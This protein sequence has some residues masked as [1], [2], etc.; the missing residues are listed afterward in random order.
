MLKTIA[1]VWL[2]GVA[3]GGCVTQFSSFDRGVALYGA[4]NWEGALVAFNDA[5]TE[6]PSGATYN[7]RGAALMRRGDVDAAIDDFTRGLALTPGDADLLYN[8]GNAYTARGRYREALADYN[9]AVAM[10]PLYAKAYF[11]RGSV[12]ARVGDRAGAVA[13]WRYAIGIER[14]ADAR[15]A[16]QRATGLDIVYATDTGRL[17]GVTVA[18]T[19][20]GEMSALPALPA[21]AGGAPA[22][23]AA[24]GL[25]RA[26]AGDTWGAQD[27]L[28]RALA[29][30]PDAARRALIERVLRA[31]EGR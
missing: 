3:L 26:I 1:L 19:A 5:V 13:D 22:D 30:E 9:E 17:G 31:V 6:E 18:P 27:D 25:A 10:A 23:L 12:R 11:N 14:D 16:M 24:R 20:T 8:R 2:A 4:G 7:N 21:A 15:A 28:R 29:S